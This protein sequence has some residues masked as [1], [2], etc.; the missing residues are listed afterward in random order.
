[1]IQAFRQLQDCVA[2]ARPPNDVVARI[3]A[4]LEE[5]EA[6]LTPYRVDERNRIAGNRWDLPGRG[7]FLI[8][9]IS[10]IDANAERACGFVTL[11]SPYLGSGGAANGGF[12]PL[13]FNELMG[14]LV[15]MG[16]RQYSRTAYLHVNFRSVARIG[17][18]LRIEVKVLREEG[19]KRFVGGTLHEGSVL[20]ADAEAL[21]VAVKESGAGA[22]N[23]SAQVDPS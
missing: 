20:V 9:P 6:F 8:P 12:L 15:Q 2:E 23:I 5:L 21:F 18:Q 16:G 4:D 11:N 17:A 13:L 10:L 7:Q 22:D 1:M 3:A 19:R 14:R